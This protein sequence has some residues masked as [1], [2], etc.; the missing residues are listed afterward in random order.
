MKQSVVI[1]KK[2]K[3]K[4]V[5]GWSVETDSF[6]APPSLSLH[7]IHS[8]SSVSQLKVL[9]IVCGPTE[10][11]TITQLNQEENF[12][13]VTFSLITSYAFDSVPRV[14]FHNVPNDLFSSFFVDINERHPSYEC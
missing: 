5:S 11:T 9:N 4:V 12:I 10:S 2:E 7:F 13:F 6:W 3:K 8:V 14:N 1:L